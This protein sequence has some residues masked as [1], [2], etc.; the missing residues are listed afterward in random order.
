[1][2]FY[3]TLCVIK[4]HG[5]HCHC[6]RRPC[7]PGRLFALTCK[8]NR[9]HSFANIELNVF[10]LKFFAWSSSEKRAFHLQ[11]VSLG[12]CS[13]P[14]IICDVRRQEDGGSHHWDQVK[15]RRVQLL[16]QLIIH[17]AGEPLTLSMIHAPECSLHTDKRSIWD[18]KGSSGWR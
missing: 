12:T 3:V 2:F 18:I 14:S 17:W 10:L 15:C 8:V 4:S 9:A 13:L 6:S 5:D 11:D 7:L 1:M 16:A